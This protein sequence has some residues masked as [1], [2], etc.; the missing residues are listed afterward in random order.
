MQLPEFEYLRPKSL[1]E[2]LAA[3]AAHGKDARI[4]SGGSDLLIN[5]L[6]S[7]T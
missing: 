2:G 4:M 1:A 3:L 6:A 5:M 7:F